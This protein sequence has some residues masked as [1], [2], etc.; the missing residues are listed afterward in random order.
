MK[1]R[2]IKIIQQKEI[3]TSMIWLTLLMFEV[4]SFTMSSTWKM[5]LANVMNAHD[6]GN[7]WPEMVFTKMGKEGN[8]MAILT[9][10]NFLTVKSHKQLITLITI[11]WQMILEVKL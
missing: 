9:T 11:R 4:I 8:A 7:E 1:N 5:C 10:N 3:L 6:K 2:S